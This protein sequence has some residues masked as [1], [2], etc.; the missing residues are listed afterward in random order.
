MTD[1]VTLGIKTKSRKPNNIGGVVRNAMPVTQSKCHHKF[2]KV[3]TTMVIRPL[4]D[5]T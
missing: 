1:Y 5:P 4:D 3:V 2:H